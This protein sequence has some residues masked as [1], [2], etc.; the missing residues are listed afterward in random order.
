MMTTSL[1]EFFEGSLS[2]ADSVVADAPTSFATSDDAE[3]PAFEVAAAVV[4]VDED[5]VS[6]EDKFVGIMDE[7][8]VSA[9]VVV[10]VDNVVGVTHITTSA[11]LSGSLLALA[12]FFGAREITF[13][14]LTPRGSSSTLVAP[15]VLWSSLLFLWD[16]CSAS[17]RNRILTA[18]PLASV[19]TTTNLFGF[20]LFPKIC[21]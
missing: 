6:V 18:C 17:F 3:V 10:T 13:V 1:F 2:T 12:T 9:E 15:D 5:V 4:N 11:S 14:I 20:K 8:G 7:E 16:A 19:E 21:V